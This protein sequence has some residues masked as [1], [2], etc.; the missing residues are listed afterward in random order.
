MNWQVKRLEGEVSS[1]PG[2]SVHPHRFGGREFRFGNAEIG[3]VHIGGVVDIPFPRAMRD[4]LLA[5]GGA[6]QHHWVPNSGWTTFRVRREEQM[7]HALWL[8][9]LSYARYVI[10]NANAPQRV[11]EEESLRLALREPFRSLLKQFAR[12]IP[13][14]HSNLEGHA[15]LAPMSS[16]VLSEDGTSGERS[17]Q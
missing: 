7:Q 15:E 13:E 3:H 10:K 16:H 1:W 4:A 12:Q 8:M 14:G 6:G 11:F 2:V 5:E 17:A 9:R